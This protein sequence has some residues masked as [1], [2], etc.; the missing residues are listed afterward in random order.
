MA[1]AR[2]INQFIVEKFALG[3]PPENPRQET[4]RN[5]FERNIGQ[6]G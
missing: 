2:K 1:R 4:S 5:D 3:K 6:G